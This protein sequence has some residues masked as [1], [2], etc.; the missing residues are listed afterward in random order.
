MKSIYYI[1]VKDVVTVQV[2]KNTESAGAVQEVVEKGIL[3]AL[4][5]EDEESAEQFISMIE[6]PKT[7]EYYDEVLFPTYDDEYG[8]QTGW[9]PGVSPNGPELQTTNKYSIRSLSK[10]EH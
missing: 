3:G 9:E 5:F 7:L 2:D 1:V 6:E 4:Y 10:W 8:F